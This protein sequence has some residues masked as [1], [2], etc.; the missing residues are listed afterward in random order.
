MPAHLVH[1]YCQPVRRVLQIRDVPRAT[2]CRSGDV[3]SSYADNLIS[4]E[5]VVRANAGIYFELLGQKRYQFGCDRLLG[6]LETLLTVPLP[7]GGKNFG[8]NLLQ[9]LSSPV[10]DAFSKP[11]TGDN[12]L[13]YLRERI[14]VR[15]QNGVLV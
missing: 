11:A 12:R 5:D 8:V 4:L 14:H 3:G 2:L 6:R 10:T 9:R 7:A 1:L 13:T 15:Y